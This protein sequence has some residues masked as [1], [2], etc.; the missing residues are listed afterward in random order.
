MSDTSAPGI[1]VLIADDQALVRGG[2]QMILSSQPDIDVV[3]TAANGR[4]AVTLTKKTA[5]DIVLMDVRMPVMDGLEATR[6]ILAPPSTDTKVVM[7]TTFE[8]DDHVYE[9]LSAGASGFLL[10]E[11]R[12]EVLADAVRTVAGGE[13]LLAPSVL[14]RLVE[15]HQTEARRAHPDRLAGLTEREVELLR[16]IGRG[17]SNQEIAAT[18]WITESTVKTHVTR[19]FRK[20]DLR[21]RAQAV[22]AAYETGL[23][24]PGQQA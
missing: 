24:T 17:A 14:R 12:P 3:A 9:A 6:R 2:L 18:L 22:V 7:L 5:P 1:R 13:A 4:E 8:L 19:I 23:I 11:T 15:R 20:L 21:D 16:L 10:K